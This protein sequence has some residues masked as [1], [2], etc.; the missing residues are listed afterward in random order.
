[1]RREESLSNRSLS[2]PLDL[3]TILVWTDPRQAC[4]QE[5]RLGRASLGMV[6]AVLP[7]RQ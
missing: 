1:M 5:E 7:G 4:N 6:C 3:R 2:E